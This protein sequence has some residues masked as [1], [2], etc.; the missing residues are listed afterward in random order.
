MI[1]FD[2]VGK[3]F[4]APQERDRKQNI[5]CEIHAEENEM[6]PGQDMIVTG[7]IGLEGTVLA[8]EK[9]EE[10]LR[11]TLPQDLLDTARSFR[12]YLKASPEAAVAR[13]HGEIAMQEVRN[14]GI[15][16]ALWQMAEQ[17]KVGMTVYL[18]KIPVR[19]ETIEIC[20]VLEWNPYELLSGGCTIMAVDNSN[21]VIPELLDQGIPA[22]FIG[23]VTDSN[24]RVILNGE[25]V[26]YLNRPEPDEI[27]KL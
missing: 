3:L 2:I 24:D 19:Q 22:A 21:D 5:F 20:E 27:E 14:G 15:F 6:K 4:S 13:R 12:E 7:Y 16:A 8:A 23:K 17:Y 26:R 25:N 1:S 11:K 9:L 18:K 10:R